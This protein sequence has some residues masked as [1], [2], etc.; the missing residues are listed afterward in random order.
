[1]RIEIGIEEVILITRGIDRGGERWYNYVID[2][3]GAI[4]NE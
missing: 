3:K 2:K 4:K 1:M